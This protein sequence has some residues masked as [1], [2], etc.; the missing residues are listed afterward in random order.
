M[1]T[2]YFVQAGIFLINIVFGLYLLTLILRFMLQ[3]I[4]AD[5]YN[6]I[7]RLIV[8]ITDPALRPL[9]KYVPGYLGIDCSLIL[10]LFFV[11]GME[12]CL[13][14][15]MLIRDLPAFSG[16]LVLI[17]AHLLQTAIYIYL[18]IIL[19][20]IIISW[21][22]P[23]AYNPII[24]IMYQLS[25]PV[26]RP[27]RKILPPAGGF[28]WTPMIILIIINL[29]LILMVAPLMDIGNRLCGLPARIL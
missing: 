5:F 26:L 3:Q 29:I 7:S 25:D 19:A 12:L 21:I 11:Q 2:A 4:R 16:L 28:D 8:K 17:P 15:L 13:I 24:V 10:L 1:N 23:T 9:R 22:N 14:A 27:L 20:Q 18:F 6:P